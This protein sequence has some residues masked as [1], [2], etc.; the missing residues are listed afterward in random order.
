MQPVRWILARPLL[1]LVPLRMSLESD[2]GCEERA[3]MTVDVIVAEDPVVECQSPPLEQLLH[4]SISS[5]RPSPKAKKP[6]LPSTVALPNVQLVLHRLAEIL[7]RWAQLC[8]SVF[9][10]GPP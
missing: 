5:S 8:F 3:Q 4:F 7:E 1:P 6:F 2:D 9:S 10:V